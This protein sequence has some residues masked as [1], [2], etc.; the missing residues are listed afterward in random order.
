[1]TYLNQFKSSKSMMKSIQLD[2]VDIWSRGTN[3]WLDVFF[4]IQFEWHRTGG[5]Q[6]NVVRTQHF[7]GGGE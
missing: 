1:M 7:G 6:F 5:L 3:S 4:I 2:D